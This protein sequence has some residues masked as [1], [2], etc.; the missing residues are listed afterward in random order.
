MSAITPLDTAT[1]RQLKR[2]PEYRAV[3]T[4][5]L[6]ELPTHWRSN[7]LKLVA[8][9]NPEVLGEE[10]HPDY[11]LRYIDI[12]NVDSLGRVHEEQ[13]FRFEDAPSRARRRVRHGDV[14]I[15]TVRTYLRAI[16]AIENPPDNL[17]VSTGFAALRPGDEYEPRFLWR[18]IQSNEFVDA[19]VSHSEGVSYP[20][21]NPTELG[22]LPVW[23][24]PLSEQRAIAAF[25]DRETAR[26]DAL[27]GYKERLISL[28]EEKRQAVI[29][30]AVTRGLDP[31]APF[32]DSGLPWLGMVPSHWTVGRLKHRMTRVEQGWSPQC[33]NRIAEPGEWGVLKVG[34]MNS[35]IYDESEC[36]ALPPE[37]TPLPELEIRVGDVLMSRSNT[38]ELVGMTGI[39]HQTQGRILLC[40]KL[41]RVGIRRDR[42]D[43]EFAVFL[44]RS[45]C[46]RTQIEP[47]ASGA[48]PSMRNISAGIVRNL[49]FAFP[50][51]DEQRE[52]AANIKGAW[53]RIDRAQF[54]IRDSIG[55]L[56]EYRTALISA[57]VAGQ[58]DVRG[59]VIT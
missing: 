49:V 37:L 43:P 29:S 48:S 1:V 12:S 22:G 36:K 5:T 55:R 53:K 8:R 19:V 28:L 24:P 35:G 23:I 33:D 30:H 20:A 54:R 18:L 32:T 52:I 59:E 51:P 45:S 27:I 26:L 40:D 3:Q 7:R 6:H 38:V 57:A 9:I 34:C 42:L 46:S 56:Q 17:I 14:L 10:T 13:N 50:P 21:I 31:A 44:L 25:L 41:Y 16:T 11:E 47:A 58:I 15:S 39:V 2:Y 4:E